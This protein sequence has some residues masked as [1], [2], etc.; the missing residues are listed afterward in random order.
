MTDDLH[1]LTARLNQHEAICMEQSKATTKALTVLETGHT[2]ILARLDEL[3]KTGWRIVMAVMLPLLGLF[4]WFFIQVWPAQ[5]VRDAGA[6]TQQ[7]AVIAQSQYTAQD[8]ARDRQTSE[9]R[10]EALM[11]AIQRLRR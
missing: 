3:N 5:G 4:A 1:S 9:A 2:A 8:A 10:D 6:A 11:R 7:R